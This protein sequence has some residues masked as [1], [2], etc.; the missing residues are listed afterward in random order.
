M[1]GTVGAMVSFQVQREATR[2][3]L[4]K[5]PRTVALG[6]GAAWIWNIAQ[7]L[8]PQAIQIVDRFHIKEHLSGVAKAIYGT[9]SEAGKRWAQRRHEELDAGRW[10]PLVAALARQAPHSEEARNC[11]Q[12]LQR[13]RERMRYP[14]FHAQELWHLHRR[15]G[16]WLQASHW[17]PAQ[18]G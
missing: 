5:A 3:R 18:T 7:E 14:E 17:N 13:N 4:E 6:D 15:A 2:R 10:R 8:A 1:V 9:A 12:C 11:V 16:G